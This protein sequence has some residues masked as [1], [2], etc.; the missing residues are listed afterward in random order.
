MILPPGLEFW[1]K[2]YIDQIENTPQQD[3][4]PVPPFEIPFDAEAP[5]ISLPSPDSL[6]LKTCDL[7]D[8]LNQRRTLRSYSEETLSLHE[9]SFLLWSSQGIQK[10]ATGERSFRTV[11]SA[12]ARHAFE[13]LLLCTSIDGLEP[14]VYR[15][16]ASQH[17][18]VALAYDDDRI[19]G[20][21]DGFRNIILPTTSAV[22]FMWICTPD[23]MTWKYGARG[24]RYILMDAGHIC[25]N[26][27]LAA[28]SIGCGACAI[29]VF[30][31]EEVNAQ[32]G[33]DG[34]SQF[35][36]YAS[37]VGKRS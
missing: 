1:H 8:L 6:V 18:L 22:T 7:R 25:Q 9:L 35:L 14:D 37:S 15:Y 29:G 32:L 20:L 34:S 16:V 10:T 31:D 23:R 2:T 13:T 4:Q 36:T 30:D 5:L 24:F 17:S 28:E 27:Y 26:L 21:I 11:P 19:E 3:N 12:G 33:L